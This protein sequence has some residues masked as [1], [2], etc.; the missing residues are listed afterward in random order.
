MRGKV[1]DSGGA[2]AGR[3]IAVPVTPVLT[4]GDI[5]QQLFTVSATDHTQAVC[6][7][8]RDTCGGIDEQ[9]RPHLFDPWFR[10]E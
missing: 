7:E 1:G 6:F 3:P 8:V 9:A 5:R 2:E 10:V 4:D